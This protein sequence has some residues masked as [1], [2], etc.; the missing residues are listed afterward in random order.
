MVVNDEELF[1]LAQDD[2]CGER[3]RVTQGELREMNT[4]QALLSKKVRG[5]PSTFSNA[6]RIQRVRSK[7]ASTKDGPRINGVGGLDRPGAAN[8]GHEL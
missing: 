4:A 3:L 1:M 6:R 8:P 5:S 2:V 7:P